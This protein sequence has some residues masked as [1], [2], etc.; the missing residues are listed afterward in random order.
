MN[1]QLLES[2]LT[3]YG[4]TSREGCVRGVI[5][6]A[7]EG[8]VDSMTTDVMGN[9]I[10]VKKGSGEGKRI[11][12]SSHMDH[13]GLM[14]MDAQENGYLRVCNVGGIRPANM[15]AEHVAFE[16]GAKG[17]VGADEGV[18]DGLEIRHLYIDVG[19]E[20]REEALAIAPIGEIAVMA[21]RMAKL[22]AHRLA[23]PAMDD[24]IAC[25]IQAQV[26]LDLPKEIQ[27]DV[28]AVFSVQEEVGLRGAAAA[29][30]S[31]QP[32]MGIA[33][34]VTGVGDV[35]GHEQ[36]VPMALGKGA[37]V[38]IMDRSLI[39]TPSVVSLLLDT[40]K[41]KEIPVQREVLPYGGTDAGAIQKTGCGVP[42][43]VISIPCRYI[44]SA[45]ETVD[46]RDVQAAHDLLLAVV[47]K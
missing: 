5:A 37:A 45:A 12:L 47:G 20:S 25:F 16:N 34:D 39:C 27:N 23:S 18:K 17:V 21:P 36:H 29:A 11:M 38:K 19:A 30:F 4:A 35:P 41:E 26:M 9:L 33:L 46:L 14:V 7:L 3:A 1:M 8:H 24:R 44:H 15:I 31:M 6:A 10:A 42:S 22:G 40:A 28:V 2:I 32:D 43:G 13:I